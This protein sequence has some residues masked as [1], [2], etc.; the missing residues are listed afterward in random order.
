MRA[1]SDR[2][3]LRLYLASSTRA[4]PHHG[5]RIPLY[6]SISKKPA[7]T[8]SVGSTRPAPTL[9]DDDDEASPP[10]RVRSAGSSAPAPAAPAPAAGE[11]LRF[12]IGQAIEAKIDEGWVHGEV[13]ALNYR[14]DEWPEGRTA[15][16][17]IKLD[18][19]SLI[20]APYDDDCVVRA[21]ALVPSLPKYEEED[22]WD[23][24]SGFGD[25]NDG[26]F[27]AEVAASF[28]LV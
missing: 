12:E 13:V 9:T 6:G 7:A 28:G 27:G 2:S 26:S 14:E 18:D 15:P 10:K 16:Y 8:P 22:Y 25:R 11:G 5:R 24:S 3:N 20:F 4:T 23:G 17:Q 1:R 21:R 19:G